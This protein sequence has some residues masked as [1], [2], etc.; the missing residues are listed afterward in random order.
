MLANMKK[1]FLDSTKQ[2]WT[3]LFICCPSLM[4]LGGLYG[5]ENTL[6]YTEHALLP[7]ELKWSIWS[8]HAACGFAVH[9]APGDSVMQNLCTAP[10]R[11]G[12][13]WHPLNSVLHILGV[14]HKLFP[15][16]KKQPASLKLH[17]AL[18][19]E[20]YSSLF[21]TRVS[22]TFNCFAHSYYTWGPYECVRQLLHP[23]L[24]LQIPIK[25]QVD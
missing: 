15:R 7:S 10:M 21:I 25:V 2:M 3:N 8:P 6:F 17:R 24:P 19:S 16:K 1:M 20:C 22:R 4:L 12:P 13:T 23:V 18:P 14:V 5:P 9:C 11:S